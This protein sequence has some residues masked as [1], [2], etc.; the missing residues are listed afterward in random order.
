[1]PLILT[2][3]QIRAHTRILNASLDRAAIR[4]SALVLIETEDEALYRL[5]AAHLAHE[6]FLRR[7]DDTDNPQLRTSNL[8]V[9]FRALAQHSVPGTAEL[10]ERLFRSPDF[11]AL[12]IRILALLH[13]LAAVRP[14]LPSSANVLREAYNEGLGHV[15][16]PDLIANHSPLA[17]QVFEEMVQ[18]T[19]VDH[20]S[21][22]D[23]LHTGLVPH[24]G[25][26]P[27]LES[28]R[29]SLR[30]HLH[31]EVRVAVIESLFDYRSKA[32]FGP[33]MSPPVPPSWDSLDDATL[34][35]LR[36][37]ALEILAGPPIPAELVR[38]VEDAVAQIEAIQE[39][40]RP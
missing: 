28:C 25:I 32:W 10:C 2:D 21:L 11:R 5:L 7:L 30:T 12:P 36:D 24:R 3:E 23:M 27:V 13:T 1:M 18:G 26:I 31:P 16:G 4:D 22:V 40:R 39:S 14:M 6:A 9:L 34:A 35:V 38:A 20:V 29:R 8:F 33:A 37:L 17:L 15:F 19:V